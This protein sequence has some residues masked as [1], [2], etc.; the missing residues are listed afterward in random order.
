MMHLR[1]L[2]DFLKRTRYLIKEG[3]C[4]FE[5]RKDYDKTYLEILV[6]DFN[7]SLEDAWIHLKKKSIKLMDILNSKLHSIKTKKNL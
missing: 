4:R 3:S 5:E 7:I 6:E 1:E 2:I